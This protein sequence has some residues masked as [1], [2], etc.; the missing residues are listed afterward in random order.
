MVLKYYICFAN[1]DTILKPPTLKLELFKGKT[2]ADG[3][4]PVCIRVTHKGKVKRKSIASA[5]EIEWDSKNNSI[6]PRSRKDHATV[7][8]TIETEYTKYLLAFN[9]LKKNLD[10][11]PEDVFK[12]KQV[13]SPLF[14]VNALL[15]LETL[16]LKS[17]H[18][19]LSARS[20]LEKIMRYA[21]KDFPIADITPR[22]IEGFIN[23]C[24]LHEKNKK[25]ET[26]N[27]ENTISYGIKFIGRIARYAGVAIELPKLSFSKVVKE[28]L[29]IEE[30]AKFEGLNIRSGTLAWHTRNTFMLQFYFRGM[31]IGD[32]LQ[33]EHSYIKGDRLVYSTGKTGHDHDIKIVEA[34]RLILDQYK[35]GRYI[36]PWL[37]YEN[38]NKRELV[39]EVK[40]RTACINRHL[41]KLAEKASIDKPLTTHIARHSFA[42]IADKK[43]NG[44]IK[45][46]QQLLGHGSRKMTELYLSDLRKLDEM[47]SDADKIYQ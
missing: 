39:A 30:L 9:A 28:K 40:N 11:N 36:L 3:R 46:I 27:S 29:T 43:L 44:D 13:I 2:L 25:G 42:S 38:L 33:L 34:C 26:G 24:K 8:D 14:R 4:Y 6:K 17:E 20:R 16:R 32:L 31:R 35:G 10:F 12:E 37:R 19:Y 41:K 21:V 15:H 23:H 22:W 1:L 18:S 45:S 7:N 47:D 5:L